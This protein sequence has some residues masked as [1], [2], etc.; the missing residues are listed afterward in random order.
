[1]IARQIGF[2]SMTE[3]NKESVKTLR[4]YKIMSVPILLCGS[5]CWVGLK[6][7]E[8]RRYKFTFGIGL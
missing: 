2:K 6:D 1:M 8:N 5:E 4:R 7:L 3:P